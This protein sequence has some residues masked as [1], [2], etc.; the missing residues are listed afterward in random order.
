MEPLHSSHHWDPVKSR[1]PYLWELLRNN[2]FLFT[3]DLNVSLIASPPSGSCP[4]A[5]P[6]HGSTPNSR[7]PYYKPLTRMQRIIRHSLIRTCHRFQGNCL[8]V[9]WILF[10]KMQTPLWSK[11]K[12]LTKSIKITITI[13]NRTAKTSERLNAIHNH[14]KKVK[15]SI[16]MVFGPVS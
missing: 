12:V 4:I 15:S 7:L 5:S 13:N 10:S 16:S 9:T 2:H 14:V 1:C 3:Y 8:F 11:E 6:W